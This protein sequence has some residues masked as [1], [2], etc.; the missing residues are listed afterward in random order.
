MLSQSEIDA[1]LGAVGTSDEAG[2]PLR[3]GTV[4]LAPS[5]PARTAASCLSDPR[6]MAWVTPPATPVPTLDVSAF[7]DSTDTLY[8]LSK[9]G[10]GSAGPL[11]AALTDQ[12][13]RAAVR[14][15]ETFGGADDL[16]SLRGE[17]PQPLFALV[18]EARGFRV[19][20][21][22]ALLADFDRLDELFGLVKARHEYR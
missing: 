18:A 16:F 21:S 17:R 13:L 8:L 11:V 12:V 6:I 22:A 2:P 1:L 5:R 10:A 9:D 3:S 7:P 19:T 20:D 14:T 4:A 15:A